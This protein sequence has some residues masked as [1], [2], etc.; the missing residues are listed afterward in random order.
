[1]FDDDLGGSIVQWLTQLALEHVIHGA[2]RQ[3]RQRAAGKVGGR[4]MLTY[5]GGNGFRGWLIHLG[6]GWI[7][8]VGKESAN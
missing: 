3:G 4:Q 2:T 7:V 1:M 5:F 6:M 8:L